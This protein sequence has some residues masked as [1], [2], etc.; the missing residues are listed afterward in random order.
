MSMKIY[1]AWK[2]KDTNLNK[3][4]DFLKPQAYDYGEKCMKNLIGSVLDDA[5]EV[6]MAEHTYYTREVAIFEIAYRGATEISKSN[7]IM[8]GLDPS[9]GL[10]LWLLDGY[11]YIIPIGDCISDLTLPGS[12]AEDFGYYNC[13]DRPEGIS[14]ED[15]ENRGCVWERILEK[16]H[17]AYRLWHGIIDLTERSND[18]A[19]YFDMKQK[20]A[21]SK[22]KIDK[23]TTSDIVVP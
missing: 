19:F 8:P 18:F 12:T 23:T 21:V 22:N 13:A 15:W 14:E 16:G 20:L 5:I 7:H 4:I 10:N 17:N 2:I 11:I 6:E 3:F 1:W 9:F